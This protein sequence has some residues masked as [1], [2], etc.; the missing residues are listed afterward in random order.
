MYAWTQNYDPAGNL[1]VSSAIA[2][3]PI[4]FLFVSLVFLR[5][6]GHVVGTILVLLALVVAVFFYG[7]P[8]S[9]A[10]T[11]GIFGFCY[12][13]WP[14][15]WVI[16]ATVFLYK[17]AV[18]TGQFDIIR[19]SITSITEDQR[20]QLLLVTV[21]FGAFLEGAAGFGAPVA[22]TSALLVGLGFNP[23]Y[24]AGLCL[25]ANTAPVT[26]GAIG[27]PII[28]ASNLTS[29]DSFAISQMAGRQL[30]FLA[31]MTPFILIMIMD[32]KRG[33]RE[34]WPAVL[35]VASTFAIT[36][37]LT[38]NFIGPELP[39]VVSA[40]ISL[41]SLTLFLKIWQPVNVFRFN[42]DEPDDVDREKTISSTTYDF[43]QILK[44]WSP[45]LMLIGTV[46]LWSTQWFRT[47]MAGT[48][49]KIPV[50]GLDN[51][52]VKTQPI[53]AVPE[54][55]PALYEFN[56]IL[57]TGSAIMTAAILSMAFLRVTPN[58]GLKIFE[59]TLKSMFRPLYTIGMVLAFAFIANFSG[60]TS[61]LALLLAGTGALFPFFSPILGWLGVFITGSDTSATALFCGLQATT[62]QQ[63]GVSEILMVTANSTGG[64]AGKMIS[65]QSIAIACAATDQVGK[66]SNLFRFTLRHS[67]TFVLFL[68]ALTMA[69]NYLFPWM[70]PN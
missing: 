56:L 15:A 63:V 28:V 5:M 47:I 36:M 25:I 14:I 13:L 69:Q 60:Q 30:P 22:I 41:I 23:L 39:N 8:T 43:R 45:F 18:K 29:I 51:L 19:S 50:P 53:V 64:V 26:F 44:A 24:A 68:G 32:G 16:V 55:I 31:I 1:W 46:T 61:T 6:K 21:P 57:A 20:L 9:L 62:A 33:L 58:E 52:V 37:F 10:L 67:I 3:I 48:S 49:V 54:T 17:L 27:I 40:L 7:M 11:A 42:A 70:I 4:I 38:S 59:E 35:V 34:T 12:G 2:A 65:P 66:E